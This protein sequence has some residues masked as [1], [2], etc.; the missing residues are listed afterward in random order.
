MNKIEQIDREVSENSLKSVGLSIENIVA[1][2]DLGQEFDLLNLQEFLNESEYKPESS[3]FLVYRPLNIDGTVLIP[4]NGKASLVGC[5]SKQGVIELGS[6]LIST[7]SEISSTE[8]P[9]LSNIEIQNIVIQGNIGTK[10][11]LSTLVILLGMENTEYE[12]EQFPGIIYQPSDGRT[13][14]LFAS[15][16][17]MMNGSTCYKSG[18]ITARNLFK[19]LS[20]YEIPVNSE[21]I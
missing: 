21:L 8:L 19:Q 6:Q 18:L 7:L 14:L 17:F 4:T 16:K 10:L 2:L 3:P 12:P 1:T 9:Q 15:G 11:E 13:L 20:E 5:K